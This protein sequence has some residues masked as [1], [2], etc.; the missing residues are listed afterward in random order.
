MQAR[1]AELSEALEAALLAD[2]AKDEFLANVSHELRTPLNVVIGL[3]D[4]ALRVTHDVK[5]RDYLEKITGAGKN[6]STI[7]ND[8]L[9]LSKIAAGHLEFEST[10]FC[11]RKVIA[12]SRLAMAHKACLLYTS[13]CV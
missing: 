11:L 12:K 1:T 13:R 6:L 4:L 8:L 5:Q 3:A 2:R 9:D 7:I 10:A